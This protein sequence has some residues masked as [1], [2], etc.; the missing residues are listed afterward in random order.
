MPK[1]SVIIPVYNA[2]KYLAECLDSVLC[3]TLSDLEIICIN[4][5][6]TDNSAKILTEYEQ[7]DHRITVI[8]QKNSGVI[9]ARNNGISHAT[10]DLIYPLDS[11]DKIVPDALATLYK[12]FTKNKGDVITSRVE[13]FDRA[14]G[15]MILPKPTRLNFWH[16]NCSVNAALFRKADFIKSGGY[17]N[18]YAIA[19]EDYDLWLNFVYR[20]KLRF[21][22]VPKKLFFYRIKDKTESRNFQHRDLHANLVKTFFAKYPEMRIYKLIYT[23]LKPFIKLKR[24]VYRTE[25]NTVKIFKIPVKSI[26]K[27]D[28]VISIGAACFVPQVL[29]E[30]DLRDFSGPFDWMF[31]SDVITRLNFVK[32][33]FKNY[34]NYDDFEYVGENPD[35]GKCVYKNNR[36][37][38]VYNHDFP[39]GDFKDVFPKICE[40][41]ARRTN[42]FL[43]TLDKKIK[44][45]LVYSE[46]GNT[47]NISEIAKTINEICDI[48]NA[49][50]DL[51]YINHN[52]NIKLNKYKKE[53]RISEHILYAEYHYSKFPAELSQAKH[54]CKNIIKRTAK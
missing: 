42:R 1:I 14:T 27:Y 44:V 49:D 40:K 11:D 47:G 22:R 52:D 29:S 25:N 50:I 19:L 6:S 46:L 8:T 38:I 9:V 39:H 17:D 41:Y 18:K 30:L 12:A 23:V 48:Y 32:N 33:R 13:L 43:D 20:Q 3:Q 51:L 15:E 2:E 24:F 45:L 37:G 21:Y 31:G 5:G 35:N 7:K 28:S 10:A 26:R 16:A 4:D 36:S 34:F 54:I 53:K